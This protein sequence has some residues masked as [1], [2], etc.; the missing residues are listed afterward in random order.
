MRRRIWAA[1]MIAFATW[2]MATLAA[3]LNE[4]MER[5]VDG[6]VR[7]AGSIA[8]SA[9]DD[10]LA[11]IERSSLLP[12]LSASASVAENDQQ[13]SSDFFGSSDESYRDTSLSLQLR[14]AIFRWD[15]RSRWK[16]AELMHEL[17]RVDEIDRRQNFLNRVLDR[18]SAVLEAQA[19][20]DY[21]QAEQEALREEQDTIDDRVRVGLS[22]VTAQRETEARKALADA[23]LLLAEDKALSAQWALEELLAGPVP[24]LK[25][26]P[27]QLVRFEAPVAEEMA[28]IKL[29]QKTAYLVQHDALALAIA[30]TEISS[31]IAEA[32]PKLDLVGQISED[33]AS[34]SRI[35]QMRES[36]RIALELSIPLYAGGGAI[37]ALK[38]A[39]A[40][41]DGAAAG[42]ELNRRIAG[43]EA[44][45]AWRGVETA[46]RRLNA[47]SAAKNAA[48]I[49]LDATRD[50]FDVGRRTQLDVLEA[51]SAVLRAERDQVLGRYAVLRALARRESAIGD[52]DFD[53]FSRFDTLFDA[54]SAAQ[55]PATSGTE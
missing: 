13:V 6:D 10:A 27:E 16:R 47:L 39:R 8:I 44:R 5:A 45:D 25:P 37:K 11:D 14:Q 32:A 29:A 9:S 36:S 15:M 24:T 49:A 43:Q 12:S 46:Y 28:F 35:G 42:L 22:T 26:L 50:G 48:Q 20:L 31:A 40:Q 34:E 17:A 2:P 21:A 38:A 3:S 55:Q 19:E 53:D 18:Y 30:E 7:V 51:R 23:N 54:A 41:R 4:I 33:D 1:T 52:L